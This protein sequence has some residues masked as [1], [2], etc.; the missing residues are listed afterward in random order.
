M[1]FPVYREIR[2]PY[3]CFGLKPFDAASSAKQIP[4]GA[5]SF[6]HPEFLLSSEYFPEPMPAF[7]NGT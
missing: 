2:S 6:P 5:Q 7:Q 3:V 1:I 4:D